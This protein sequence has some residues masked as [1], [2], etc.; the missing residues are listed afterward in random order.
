M[1][2]SDINVNIEN[3]DKNTP[4]HYFCQKFRSPNCTD[5]FE[6]FIEKGANVSAQ[7]NNG[8]TPLHKAIFNN[9]VKV[10]MTSLLIKAGA[11]V[12]RV[13]LLGETPLHYAVRLGRE[14]LVAILLKG[15]ADVNIKNTKEVWAPVY[16]SMY[17]CMHLSIY[18]SIHLSICK[19]MTALVLTNQSLPLFPLQFFFCPPLLCPC[20]LP[21]TNFC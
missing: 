19:S 2:A 1:P 4:L 3:E 17:V 8:E 21:W 6:I 11:D 5:A 10:L 20:L 12:N 7:N 16:L 9:S 13:N 14:D 15:G 18:L